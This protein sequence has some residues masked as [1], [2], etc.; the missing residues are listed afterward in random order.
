MRV[1]TSQMMSL[2]STHYN[3]AVA[4]KAEDLD[5]ERL[6]KA[7]NGLIARHEGLRTS[8][9]NRN[10]QIVQVIN[11]ASTIGIEKLNSEKA[12]EINT[13]FDLGTAPLFRVGYYE[14]TIVVVAHH[15]IVDG[16]SMTVLCKELN[17]LYMGRE[18]KETV[19]YGEFAVTDTY[20][21]EN[22]KYWLNVFSE[23]VP[24]IELP[25]DYERPEK[26]T[27]A[28]ARK[29]EYID[30]KT[31]NQVV[32]KCTKLNIT[33]YVFY[34]ACYN[35]LLSKYSGNEDIC[36]GMPI[37]GRTSKF[38]NTIGMFVN[39]VVLRTSIDGNKT[40]NEF[41]QEIRVNSIS[42]I[43]NQNYPFGELVKKVNKQNT[44]RNPLFDVMFAYQNEVIPVI[45]FGDKEAASASIDLK[46]VKCDLNFNIVPTRDNVAISVEYS[47]DLFKEETINKFIEAYKSILAQCL[48]ETK[49]IKEITVLTEE[50]KEQINSFNETEHSYDIP[51]NTTLYSLFEE[52]AKE[53]AE[54][55]CI[56]ANEEEITYKEFKAY[57]E[58]L[59]NKIRSITNEEKSVIA[60][61]CERSFEMYGAVY[62]IIRGG[63]AYLPI[64]PN[65][66]QERIDYILS[67]SNAKA[68][69]A[70][71][72]FCHLAGNT[73]CINATEVLKSN[74]EP[75]KTEILANEKDTAY[76]IYTSG[77][78]G[79]PKV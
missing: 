12:E 31:H 40:I 39:T 3:I 24:E 18:L 66:P 45:I 52:K 29:Q 63:N 44:N 11:E 34:M 36:V 59:D 1:Y 25:T 73:P 60:V 50:E 7:V 49:Q 62:G 61:I 2:E 8:F 10:G 41:M 47:T 69:V 42:A 14:N 70:Q 72:K 27:F 75:T 16:E 32:E 56:I 67:N 37:S 20:T 33:P 48:E 26:Q 46:A 57:A 17:E 4:F 38:H 64:D 74:E 58:R 15:I 9:E 6:G 55:V 21:E 5:A 30:I 71:D 22:E 54:K 79:N 13:A 65:Y 78:T 51:A 23:S 43:D 19:Q 68:V 53:N 76:V 77:S 35:V 28:G